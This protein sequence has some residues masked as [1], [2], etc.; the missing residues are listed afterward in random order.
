MRLC[1]TSHSKFRKVTRWPLAELVRS[2]YTRQAL[3]REEVP[4]EELVVED[5]MK[6]SNMGQC[7]ADIERLKRVV[8]VV[9]FE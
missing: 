5:S 8:K 9:R 2:S 1:D 7:R 3:P 6:V 4:L